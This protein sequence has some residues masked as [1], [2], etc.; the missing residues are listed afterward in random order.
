M[1]TERTIASGD[2]EIHTEAFGDAGDPPVLLI[3]GQ[4]ASMLWWPDG[5]CERLAAAGRYVIRYDNRDTGRSTSYE[6]G[7]PP[8]TGEDMVGDAV[9]VLDGH[10]ID[11]AHVVGMSMG[12]ALG[13][14]VAANHPDRA[15][16]LTVMD[17]TFATGS[18]GGLPGPDPAYLAHL[19][20]WADADLSDPAVMADMIVADARAL[21]GTRHPHDDAASRAFVERDLARTRDPA[22]LVNHTLVEEGDPGPGLGALTAPLL[23][24]HGT[25]DPLLPIEHGRALAAA[26][27]GSTL[28]E[29]EGG[30]HEVHEGDW[31]ELVAAIVAHTS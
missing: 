14:L 17:S 3:M 5:F 23:V 16:T 24:I 8:Y 15:L 22:A 19:G 20:E 6:P 11:R 18:P 21:S 12:G 29:I 27:P 28:V 2:A 9:A 10:G 7:K 1:P 13:Q 4:M 26:V 31:D 30:G 25:S